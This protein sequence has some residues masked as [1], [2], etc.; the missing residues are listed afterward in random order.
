MVM[1]ETLVTS[2]VQMDAQVTENATKRKAQVEYAPVLK[3]GLE[4]T[5][6]RRLVK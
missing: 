5:V 4:T 1:K 3:D 6:L 2:S